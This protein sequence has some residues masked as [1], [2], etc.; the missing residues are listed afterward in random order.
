MAPY[1][2]LISFTLDFTCPW[3]YL[4]KRRL[5][6]TLSQYRQQHPPSPDSGAVVFTLSFLPYQ[7][8]PAFPAGEERDKRRWLSEQP[9]GGSE[10]ATATFAEKMAALGAEDG[11]AFKSLSAGVVANTLEAHRV[12]HCLQQQNS[13]QGGGAFEPATFVDSVYESYF[14]NGCSPSSRE[15]LMLACKAA[16]VSDEAAADIVDGDEGLAEVKMLIR[17]QKM[18]GVDSVPYVVFEGRKRDFTLVGARSVEEYGKVLAN[19]AKESV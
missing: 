12:L 19:I 11:I 15:T 14:E 13:A 5:E 10:E 16:G 17:E 9:H 1:E 8:Q 3:T 4:G 7:L 2:S 18:N 6:K